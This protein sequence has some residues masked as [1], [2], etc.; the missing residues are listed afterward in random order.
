MPLRENLIHTPVMGLLKPGCAASAQQAT[1]VN[2]NGSPALP[3]GSTD[4]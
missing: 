1:T 3:E 2:G 4:P